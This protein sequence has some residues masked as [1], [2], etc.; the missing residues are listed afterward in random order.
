[1]VSETTRTFA[2]DVAVGDRIVVDEYGLTYDPPLTVTGVKSATA[3]KYTIVSFDRPLFA[4]LPVDER[5]MSGRTELWLRDSE[6]VEVE[7]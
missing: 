4:H 2:R 7:R 6:R 1:M 3:S 5:P